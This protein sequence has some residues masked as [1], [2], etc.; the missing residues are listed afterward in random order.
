MAWARFFTGRFFM[1]PSGYREAMLPSMRGRKS[2]VRGWPNEA[3]SL[4]HGP[5]LMEGEMVVAHDAR[6]PI[7][8]FAAPASVSEGELTLAIKEIADLPCLLRNAVEGLEYDRLT[9]PYRPGGWTV[10][11]LVHHIADSHMN[12]FVRIRLALTEEWPVI[13]TYDEKAWA[14]LHD[15]V[16]PVAWSLEL[17]E[18]LHARWVMLLGSLSEE[19]MQRGYTHP[20]NGRTTVEAATML[21]AWHSRHHLAHITQLRLT[22]GW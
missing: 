17:I 3:T 13:P 15:A 8:R 5:C 1:T 2:R 7:G 16:A 9:T 12:A 11:Q 20:V 22:E 10:Q 21:Y 19:Q 14:E 6:Y 4:A 18:A